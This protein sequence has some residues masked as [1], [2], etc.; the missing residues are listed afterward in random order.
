[1]K[2]LICIL[3]LF[4]LVAVANAQNVEA[5]SIP[6]N[7]VFFEALGSGL[8]GS[9]NYE[10]QLTK[11]PGLSIRAG[12]GVY[13]DG[14]VYVTLPVSAQFAFQLWKKNYLETG[15]GYTLAHHS[16]FNHR[17]RKDIDD[18]FGVR[19]SFYNVL[20]NVAFKRHFGHDWMWKLQVSLL[21]NEDV[22]ILYPGL[23]IGKNF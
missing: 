7:T 15:L 10:Y 22:G 4:T 9:A 12:I 19:N 13:G 2:T 18:D 20:I 21:L 5:T 17:A 14:A 6:R 8:W 3:L 1:M 16:N 11:T 23:A